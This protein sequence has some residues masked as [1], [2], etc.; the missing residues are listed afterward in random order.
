MK[1]RRA[2]DATLRRVDYVDLKI[3]GELQSR[4]R[5]GSNEG[6]SAG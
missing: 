3:I 6:P 1:R 2:A 4:R 5:A